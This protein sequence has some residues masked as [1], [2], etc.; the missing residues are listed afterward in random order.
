MEIN[1]IVRGVLGFVIIISLILAVVY[2]Y[3]WLLLTLF[4]GINLFQSAFTN[5]CP[6]MWLLRKFGVREGTQK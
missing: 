4:V 2:S 3:W 1:R 6:L 5:T